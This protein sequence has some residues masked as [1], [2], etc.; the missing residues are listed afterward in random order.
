MEEFSSKAKEMQQA[1]AH[2]TD[3]MD[4]LSSATEENARG[5]ENVTASTTRLLKNVNNVEEQA[6]QNLQVVEEL[7]G[8][9]AQFKYE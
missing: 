4:G 3:V 1:I 8:I 9:I 6:G 5:I 7:N 2:I